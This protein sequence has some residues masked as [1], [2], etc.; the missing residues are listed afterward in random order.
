MQEDIDVSKA[1]TSP[2]L[3]ND[4]INDR[5]D[6]LYRILLSVERF[7][8]ED[9]PD[10]RQKYFIKHYGELFYISLIGTKVIR[11]KKDNKSIF[12]LNITT[13]C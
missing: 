6:P 8:N 10:E 2:N 9:Q 12:F 13:S 4:A 7:Q 5:N 3:L 11:Q 1:A